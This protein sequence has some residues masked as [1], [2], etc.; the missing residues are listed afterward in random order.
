MMY[1]VRFKADYWGSFS[2]YD[3]D[4]NEN[5]EK[6][7]ALDL[8]NKCLFHVQVILSKKPDKVWL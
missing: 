3:G 4:G 8:Q 2:I 7:I 5:G 6:E 1:W